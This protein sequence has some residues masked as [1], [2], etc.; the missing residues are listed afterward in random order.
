M[1]MIKDNHVWATGSITKAVAAARRA[2]GF[3]VKVEVECGSEAEADEAV[4]AGADV[5]MLDNFTAEG[6]HVAAASVKA[7]WAERGRSGFLV[8]VSGGIT[9]ETAAAFFSKDIDILSFGSMTQSVPHVDFS[10]KVQP[11]AGAA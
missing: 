7:R 4:E 3:A 1:V 9:E 8:E 10:L 2:A 6:A 5:V 11:G